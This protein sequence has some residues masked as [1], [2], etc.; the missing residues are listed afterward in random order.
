MPMD[1]RLAHVV[2]DA[3]PHDAN[4]SFG[5]CVVIASRIKEAFAVDLPEPDIDDPDEICSG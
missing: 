2:L 3:L 4:L 5:D 1:T